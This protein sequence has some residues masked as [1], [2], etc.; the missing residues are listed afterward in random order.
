MKFGLTTRKT[1]KKKTTN[2]MVSFQDYKTTGTPIITAL[3]YLL[4]GSQSIILTK[5]KIF[6]IKQCTKNCMKLHCF[7]F[8]NFFNS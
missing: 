5:N 2:L 8:I 6:S 1:P 7:D 3:V 4:K